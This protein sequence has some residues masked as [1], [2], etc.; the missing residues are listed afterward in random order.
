[1]SAATSDTN[2]FLS[3]PGKWMTVLPLG[4]IASYSKNKHVCRFSSER[5]VHG[6]FVPRTFA[7][8]PALETNYT[9]N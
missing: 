4:D 6:S 3:S 8:V 9:L 5:R 1:M 2:Y 7:I